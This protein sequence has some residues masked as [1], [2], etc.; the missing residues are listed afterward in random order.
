MSRFG[1]RTRSGTG[2]TGW[3]KRTTGGPTT[4]VDEFTASGTWVVPSGVTYAIAHMI[5]GGG[6]IG[7][8]AGAGGS[9]SVAFAGGTVTAAG[10]AAHT[11]NAINDA[12]DRSAGAAN[13][14]RGAKGRDDTVRSIELHGQDGAYIVAGDTVT[15]GANISVTVGSAGTAGTNGV[16]GGSGVVW[17]EYQT[18]G[19]PI[20]KVA[21][22][23]A[24]GTWT[25]PTGVTYAVANIRAGGGGVST[26]SSN[27]GN[28]SVAFAGGTVTATGGLSMPRRTVD[29]TRKNGA[30]V[31]SGGFAQGQDN[32]V[33][34][35]FMVRSNP[36]GFVVAGDTV[37]PGASISVTVGAAGGGGSDAAPSGGSGYVW[38]EYEQA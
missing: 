26:G 29:N 19:S 2:V 17:I 24:N 20:K 18:G 34:G 35:G 25:V 37:T 21:A 8:G 7:A 31:N 13:S 32:A 38:I 30:P 16:A 5:G 28:S 11:P 1:D 22:F 33:D 4:K 36:G 27:G 9:S 10:G 15:P 14:G 12:Q 23:T 3:T 6:G